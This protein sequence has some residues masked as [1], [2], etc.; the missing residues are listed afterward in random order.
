M[1]CFLWKELKELDDKYLAVEREYEKAVQARRVSKTSCFLGVLTGFAGS[2]ACHMWSPRHALTVRTTSRLW[3]GTAF[4]ARSSFQRIRP[5]AIFLSPNK[6]L[7]ELQKQFTAKQQPFLDERSKVLAKLDAVEDE[8][9]PAFRGEV[10]LGFFPWFFQGEVSLGFFVP[11][12]SFGGFRAAEW[13]L[14]FS[15]GERSNSGTSCHLW[16]GD[17]YFQ[18][19]CWREP[20]LSDFTRSWDL[21]LGFGVWTFSHFSCSSYVVWPLACFGMAGEAKSKGTPACSGF[22]KQVVIHCFTSCRS[23]AVLFSAA[24]FLIKW[25]CVR[26]WRTCRHWKIT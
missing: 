25:P 19:D 18:D 7:Q 5:K 2:S 23:F 12:T 4:L 9:E 13:T 1:W 24:V 21:F 26:P 16:L 11:L 10:S 3:T 6:S 15:R 17:S 14:F 20:F 8:E 22:W